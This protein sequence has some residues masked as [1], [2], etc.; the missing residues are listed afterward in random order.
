MEKPFREKLPPAAEEKDNKCNNNKTGSK[1]KK[2]VEGKSTTRR[3]EKVQILTVLLRIIE[4]CLNETYRKIHTAKHLSDT[5]PAQWLERRRC[6]SVT[7][8]ELCFKI[9]HK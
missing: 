5:F 7:A 9:Q 6:F 3:R 4:M 1:S 2:I 8:F